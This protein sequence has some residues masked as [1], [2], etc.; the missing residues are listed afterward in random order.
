LP[1]S[2]KAVESHSNQ[3][4]ASSRSLGPDDPPRHLETNLHALGEKRPRY[5]PFVTVGRQGRARTLVTQHPFDLSPIRRVRTIYIFVFAMN[6]GFTPNLLESHTT[7]NLFFYETVLLLARLS[8]DVPMLLRP[9]TPRYFPP[10]LREG[11]VAGRWDPSR[12]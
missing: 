8:K 11:A 2:F 9:T 3:H 4:R 6:T 1:V 12:H 5:C 10:R 7:W